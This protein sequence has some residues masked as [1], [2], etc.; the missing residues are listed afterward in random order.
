MLICIDGYYYV[1]LTNNLAQR[2]Q[3]HSSG[4]GPTYTKTTKPKLLVWFESHSSREAATTREKQLKGWS[5]RKKQSLARGDLQLGS[6]ARNLWFPLDWLP[7]QSSFA[8]LEFSNR[9]EIYFLLTDW[10]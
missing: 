4:K 9:R 1:G 7:T 2:I 6:S 8:V 5:R 3:D 10:T